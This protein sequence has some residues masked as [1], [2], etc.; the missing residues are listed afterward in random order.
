MMNRHHLTG[1]FAFL[2]TPAGLAALEIKW[3][4]GDMPKWGEN[5]LSLKRRT[6][7]NTSIFSACGLRI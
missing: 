1:F 4:C 3:L 5:N 6:L 7:K 2:G